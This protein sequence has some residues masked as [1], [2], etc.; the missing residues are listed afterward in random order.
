MTATRFVI[1]SARGRVI[2]HVVR[3]D[4]R[5]HLAAICGESVR[6]EVEKALAQAR[7]ALAGMGVQLR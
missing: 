1:E 5:V 3:R 2:V 4:D 6:G 7:F